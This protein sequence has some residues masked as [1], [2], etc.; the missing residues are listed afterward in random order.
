[1]MAGQLACLAMSCFLGYIAC[2]LPLC[3]QANFKK[4][5]LWLCEKNLHKWFFAIA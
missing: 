5:F 3:Q 4:V 2:W 1:M